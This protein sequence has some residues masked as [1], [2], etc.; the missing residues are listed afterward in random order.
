MGH[1]DRPFQSPKNYSQKGSLWHIRFENF[2]IE[3]WDYNNGLTAYEAWFKTAGQ[4]P[5]NRYNTSINP[6]FDQVYCQQIDEWP[7]KGIENVEKTGI[8]VLN[9]VKTLISNISKT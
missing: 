4:W 2:T 7:A 9:E 3:V 6:T 5:R 8:H 1:K